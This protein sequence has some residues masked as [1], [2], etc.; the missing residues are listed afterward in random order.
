MVVDLSKKSRYAIMALF[1][2]VLAGSQRPIT[3]RKLAARHNLPVRFLEIILNELK[4]GGFVSSIRGK[5]GGYVLARPANEITL[6]QVVSYLEH[7]SAS[8]SEPSSA[9]ADGQR[10]LA[11]LIQEANTA[12]IR[13]FEA[14]TLDELVRREVESCSSGEPNYII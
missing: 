2:L 13:I 7:R 11:L 10:V 9:E 8:L 1:E 14:C 6:A 4:Q 12:V 5:A 3:A